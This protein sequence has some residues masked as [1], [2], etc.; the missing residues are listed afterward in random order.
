MNHATQTVRGAIKGYCRPDLANELKEMA[1]IGEGNIQSNQAHHFILQSSQARLFV[2]FPF[3]LATVSCFFIDRCTISCTFLRS[4]R[5][6]LCAG[7]RGARCALVPLWYC[8]CM[9]LLHGETGSSPPS[10][11]SDASTVHHESL[12]ETCYT[13]GSFLVQPRE[14]TT[15]LDN[16]LTRAVVFA[17]ARII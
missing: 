4:V 10:V 15:N 3:A 16:Q 6:L 12:Y 2:L 7:Y 17:C 1:P 14:G 11:G 5:I 13:L 8:G 9:T